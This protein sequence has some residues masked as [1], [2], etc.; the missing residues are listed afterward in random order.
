VNG[1]GRPAPTNW[2]ARPVIG[3]ADIR[4]SLEFYVAKLGFAEDWRYAE[5][6]LLLIVQVSREGCE[7]I[8]STQ[9]PERVGHGLMFISLDPKV[10][11]AVRT[12][13]TNRSVT[14]KDGRWG[15]PLMVV[16]DPD[17][18]LLYFPYPSDQP[19]SEAKA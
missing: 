11:D 1:E 14:V 9:W 2:Y 15:Y 17:G 4:R 3:V 16:E 6:E 8:L 18:N 5:D 10:L 13:I 19:S 7:L 12:E